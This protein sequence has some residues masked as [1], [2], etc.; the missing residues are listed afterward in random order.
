MRRNLNYRAQR[1]LES[2]QG[3]EVVHF[4][5]L[6]TGVG[7]KTMALLVERGIVQVLADKVGKY[8]KDYAWRLIN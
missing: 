4:Y 7:P 3:L 1:A 2:F 8:A 6:P 5:D